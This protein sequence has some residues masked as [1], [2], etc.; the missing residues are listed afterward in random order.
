MHIHTLKCG[1]IFWGMSVCFCLKIKVD[2]HTSDNTK[3]SRVDVPAS[4]LKV[5]SPIWTTKSIV[6]RTYLSTQTQKI[7]FCKHNVHITLGQQKTKQ[8]HHFCSLTMASLPDFLQLCLV[9]IDLYCNIEIPLHR[10][11]TT[12]RKSPCCTNI[13]IRL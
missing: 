8:F 10:I 7:A 9:T 11:M 12:K 3:A 5:D 2:F 1:S 13:L 4:F 6:S